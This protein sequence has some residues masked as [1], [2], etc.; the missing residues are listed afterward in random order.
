MRLSGCVLSMLLAVSAGAV[1]AADVV[2]AARPFG[3]D[4]A[5][6]IIAQS[7]KVLSPNGVEELKQ[8]EIGGIRQWISVRGNDRRNPI[9]LYLHGGPGSVEM[10]ESYGY[11]RPWEDFFTVV[12][13]DQRGAG[14]T[15]AANTPAAMAPRMSIDGMV[16]DA[17]EMIRYLMAT[18]GKRKIF[19]LGHSWGSIVGEEIARRHPQWLHAYLGAGQIAD[20]AQSEAIGYRWALGRARAEGN[21]QAIRELE[22]LAPYPGPP[23]RL[24]LERIGAQRTWTMHYGGLA[25]GR[26]EFK[27]F[28]DARKLSPDYSN[29]ELQAIDH[30]GLYSL[31]YLLPAMEQVD[32]GGNTRFGCPIFIFNGRHDYTTSFE[33]AARWFDALQAPLKRMFW[34]EDSAHMMMQEQPGLFLMH[35]VNDVRPLAVRAGDAP[36]G[37]VASKK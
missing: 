1:H 9:L 16:A 11:Q 22:A 2:A 29:A 18:Y 20:M 5:R 19:V 21:T 7:R 37:E 8:V 13:W 23:G 32:F 33:V 24:T 30:G 4:A 10:V 31:G 15:F 34:F 35:L 12:Q 26:S 17:E 6:A 28:D 3:Q 27:P 25:W 36:P 14:K